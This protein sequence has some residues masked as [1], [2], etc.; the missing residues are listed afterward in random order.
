M[1]ARL[2]SL[3]IG[4]AAS[5]LCACAGTP[6]AV[7]ELAERTG[8]NAG[9]LGAQLEKLSRESKELAEARA[10][11]ISSLH[12]VNT[13]LRASYNFDLLL[14]K[15][16]GQG[17]S[18]QLIEVLQQW[19]KEAD[20]VFK[21]VDAAGRTRKAEILSNVTKL[22]TKADA[23]KATAQRLAKMAEADKPEDRA[24]F[25]AGFAKQVRDDVQKQIEQDDPSAKKAKEL[26]QEA[27]VASKE[28][29]KPKPQ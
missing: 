24:R 28:K 11:A 19:H 10:Q 21:G 18:L 9:I 7:R 27:G 3:T 4:A 6:E 22:D 8:A 14:T 20:E 15:K 29:T 5:L 26:L 25:L 17:Q 13:E 12:A 1:R 2:A 23:L 16:S